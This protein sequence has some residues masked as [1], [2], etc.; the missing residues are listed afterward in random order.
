[1]T[2]VHILTISFLSTLRYEF[3]IADPIKRPK[4]EAIPSLW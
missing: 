3:E 2:V 4:M 1:M